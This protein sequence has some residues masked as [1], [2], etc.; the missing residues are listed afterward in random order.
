M[1]LICL[2]FFAPLILAIYLLVRADGGRAFVSHDRP[3]GDGTIFEVWNFRTTKQGTPRT[4]RNNQIEPESLDFTK[5]G[6]VL[7]RTRLDVLPSFLNVLKGDMSLAE[8][9]QDF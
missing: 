9:L 3:R 1:G 4:F 7:Y 6:G 2:I 5:F 8:M